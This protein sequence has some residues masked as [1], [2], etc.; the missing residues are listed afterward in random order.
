MRDRARKQDQG[1]LADDCLSIAEA[2]ALLAMSTRTV[3]RWI[4]DGKLAAELR[5]GPHGPQ[6]CIPRAAVET[7][8]PRAATVDALSSL[9][10]EIERLDQQLSS[11]R[12][13][14]EDLLRIHLV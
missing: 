8:R 9:S 10:A 12:L 6:Y 14:L 3:R 2:A 11:L 4:H 7:V 5:S 1:R 13:Q